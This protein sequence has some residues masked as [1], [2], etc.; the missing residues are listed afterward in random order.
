MFVDEKPKKRILKS[1]NIILLII[2]VNWSLFRKGEM[3][4]LGGFVCGSGIG[5]I[6]YNHWYREYKENQYQ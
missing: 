3:L 1:H 6:L 2:D 5:E 4:S